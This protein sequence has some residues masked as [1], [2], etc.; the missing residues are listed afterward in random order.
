MSF[1]HPLE[2]SVKSAVS[3]LDNPCN[4]VRRKEEALDSLLSSLSKGALDNSRLIFKEGNLL[5]HI[6]SQKWDSHALE[7]SVRLVS[8]LAPCLFLE[9][10]DQGKIPLDLAINLKNITGIFKMGP[11]T[12]KVL[13]DNPF[14]KAHDSLDVKAQKLERYLE[15]LTNKGANKSLL[16]AV[17]GSYENSYEVAALLLSCLNVDPDSLN[18]SEKETPLH[19]VARSQNNEGAELAALLLA[20]GANPNGFDACDQRPLHY[21][22]C[23]EGDFAP[24]IASTLLRGGAKVNCCHKFGKMPLH[25]AAANASE[26]AFEMFK[27]FIENNA[28]FKKAN[29]VG[30]TC[31]HFAARNLGVCGPDIVRLLLSLHVSPIE[32]NFKNEI[33]LLIIL[34]E[35]LAQFNC[36]NFLKTFALLIE[37]TFLHFKSKPLDENN[38]KL[39]QNVLDKLSNLKPDIFNKK[40]APKEVFQAARKFYNQANQADINF[41]IKQVLPRSGRKL[42]I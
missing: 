32:T 14:K 1:L 4:Y 22:A 16:E 35:N 19:I 8:N 41:R 42:R 21:V 31:M 37:K 38:E 20:Y 25:F 23:N 15:V 12:T 36:S 39:F 11:L 10:N 30:D 9:L 18:F 13:F 28:D 24:Q 17:Q 27:L 2:I 26:N 40:Q 34:Q 3:I 29:L 5:H 33:P 7:K 6:V